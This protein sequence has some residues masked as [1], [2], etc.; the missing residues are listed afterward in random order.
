MAQ[1]LTPLAGLA[2]SFRHQLSRHAQTAAT[3]EAQLYYHRACIAA[4]EERYDVALVFAG[5][6]LQLAPRDLAA[7]LLVAQVHDRGLH[8]VAKAVKGYEKVIALAGY[9]GS[10]PYC[11][12]ARTALDALVSGAFTAVP[13]AAPG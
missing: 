12:A 4:S 6:A 13:T 9:D 7:R 2:R 1:R 10:N 8:D 11:A 3:E 5:K